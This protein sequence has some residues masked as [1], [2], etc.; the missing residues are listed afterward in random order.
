LVRFVPC[1]PCFR[2]RASLI[3][4]NRTCAYPKNLDVAD[5]IAAC[6]CFAPKRT[7]LDPST[8]SALRVDTGHSRTEKH[9]CEVLYGERRPHS[10]CHER[11]GIFSLGFFIFL[12]TI[13]QIWESEH[14]L[15]PIAFLRRGP[16]LRDDPVAHLGTPRSS[17]TLRGACSNDVD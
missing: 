6:V 9:L 3:E 2:S 10:M 16:Q 12:K 17:P 4:C 8:T 5:Q 13:L 11:A 1:Q 7:S 15:G 14:E